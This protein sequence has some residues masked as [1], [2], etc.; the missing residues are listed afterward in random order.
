MTISPTL[1]S[2][3]ITLVN[4][5]VVTNLIPYLLSMAALNV[6]QKS[7]DVNDSKIK[8]STIVAFVAS[9][10]SLYACYASGSEAMLYVGVVTFAGW[11]LYG[12]I[13]KRFDLKKAEENKEKILSD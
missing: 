4:L 12:L 3:F 5:A 10:Y 8:S 11:T 1:N 9:I 7:S 6:I 13:S 2:Q